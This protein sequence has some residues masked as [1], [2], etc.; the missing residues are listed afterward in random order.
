MDAFDTWAAA[1]GYP[2]TRFE[3]GEEVV[4]HSH[5]CRNCGGSWLGCTATNEE[6]LAKGSPN[7]D[8]LCDS[9]AN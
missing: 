1:K 2:P 6:C 8:G 5:E 7:F 3:D 4:A 9:C